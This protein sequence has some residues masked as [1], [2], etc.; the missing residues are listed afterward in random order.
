MHF[1][2]IPVHAC[3]CAYLLGDVHVYG[4]QRTGPVHLF[5]LY[6]RWNLSLAWNSPSR[7]NWLTTESQDYLPA[8]L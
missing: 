1:V 2:S 7:L 4:G 5:Y 3:V 8:P 6:I